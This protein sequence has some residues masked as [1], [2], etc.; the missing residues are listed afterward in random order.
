MSGR[1]AE[2]DRLRGIAILGILP[3]N[4]FLAAHTS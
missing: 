1:L 2:L 4:L 3:V